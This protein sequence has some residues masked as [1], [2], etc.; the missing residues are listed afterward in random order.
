MARGVQDRCRPVRPI[1][2]TNEDCRR[3]DAPPWR[4]MRKLPVPKRRSQQ[5]IIPS[6]RSSSHRNR[7]WRMQRAPCRHAHPLGLLPRPGASSRDMTD[8]IL[9]QVERFAPRSRMSC[10]QST[11]GHQ[12]TSRATTPI[13]S[14]GDI[15]GG[16]LS[17][18][19]LFSG[20]RYSDRIARRGDLPVPASTPPGAECTGCAGSTQKRCCAL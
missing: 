15:T 17:I 2:W 19:G 5:A 16:E 12:P 18:R 8:A 10:S 3:R 9:A 11:D 7:L 14:A 1:P 4:R 6:A 13:M 20:R